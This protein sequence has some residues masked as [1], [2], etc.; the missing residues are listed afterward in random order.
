[1]NIDP[2]DFPGVDEGSGEPDMRVDVP[3]ERAG[4][5]DVVRVRP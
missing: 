3:S 1:M 4:A 2:V 5:A